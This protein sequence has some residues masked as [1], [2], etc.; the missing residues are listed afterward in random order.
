MKIDHKVR[1]LEQVQTILRTSE[2]E[3]EAVKASPYSDGG[4]AH[5]GGRLGRAALNHVESGLA[6]ESR[7]GIWG[8]TVRDHILEAIDLQRKGRIEDAQRL[9][10]LAVNS[11]D[12]F[13]RIQAL[14]D[15]MGLDHEIR[16]S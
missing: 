2:N 15:K 1:A 13:S 3:T 14:M 10:L 11:M 5:L 6:T 7:Y 8:N 4:L 9:L 16:E 12:A